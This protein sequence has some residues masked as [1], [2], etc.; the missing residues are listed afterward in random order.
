MSYLGYHG[1]GQTHPAKE[2]SAIQ[3]LLSPVTGA[4]TAEA[5]KV[6]DPIVEKMRPMIREELERQVPTFAIYSGVT[7]GALLFIG[8]VTGLLTRKGA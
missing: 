1:L 4:L 2:Q 7:A 3:A 8:I 6:A 5:A